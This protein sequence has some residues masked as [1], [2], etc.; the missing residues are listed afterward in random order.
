MSQWGFYYDQTRCVNC[1]AC[2]FACK[3]WNDER[4]GDASINVPLSW[5]DNGIYD[6]PGAYEVAPGNP[7]EQNYKEYR[8]YHMKENWRT[9]TTVEYGDTPPNVDVQNMSLGCNHCEDPA[10]VK[11]CPMGVPYKESTIGA[12]LFN[13]EACISC[14]RCRDACPWNVP[15]FYDDNFASY[16]I[17]DPLRPRMT[18]CTMCYDRINKGLKPA[19]VA[20]CVGRALES[21]PMSELKEKH[22]YAVSTMEMFASDEIPSLGIRTKPNII[23]KPRQR[24]A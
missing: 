8:K 16:I 20:A 19:C 11:V 9:V 10:C 3:S 12:V 17:G 21:G 13:N 1:K 5:Q 24:K 14:G 2:M 22:P 6:N 18:K 15:Q 4:R 7:G 23:F